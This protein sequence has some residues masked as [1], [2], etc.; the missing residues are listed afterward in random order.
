M[1]QAIVIALFG[2]FMSCQTVKV[3][4]N[5]YRTTESTVELGAIGESNSFLKLSNDFEILSYPKLSDKIKV[6]VEVLPFTKKVSKLYKNKAKYNQKQ[7]KIAYSDSLL[8]KPEVVRIEIVD[9]VSLIKEINAEQNKNTFNY[10]DKSKRTSIINDVLITLPS[11]DIEKI[12][13]ADAYYLVQNGTSKY[14][15]A[16]YKEGKK[17]TTLDVQTSSVLGYQVA[18]FCWSEDSRG[19]WKIGDIIKEGS[20]CKGDTYRMIKPKKEKSLYKM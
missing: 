18:K 17:T 14:G 5:T 9:V 3:K 13:Q 16:L 11:S 8:V 7:T 15:I 12:R 20:S 10:I 1:K 19:K 6:H 2:L 4:N